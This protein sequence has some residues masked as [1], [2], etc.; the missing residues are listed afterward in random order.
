M[1]RFVTTDH[2]ELEHKNTDKSLDRIQITVDELV[3]SNSKNYRALI[4][5]LFSIVLVLIG[6]IWNGQ[7]IKQQN[8]IMY[9]QDPVAIKAEK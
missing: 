3:K 8:T 9:H 4:A 6:V 1:P 7:V 2:C 5:L